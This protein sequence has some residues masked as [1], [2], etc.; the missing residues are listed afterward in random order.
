MSG[1]T[2]TSAGT[3][4]GPFEGCS[5]NGGKMRAFGF[6][7]VAIGVSM[8]DAV[9]CDITAAT[10]PEPTLIKR[11][12]LALYDGAQEGDDAELT[13][14][15]R[16]AEM[17]LN[18]LGF[19]LRFHNMRGRLPD[20]A[21]VERYR[22]VLTWF[23]GSV[24]DGRAY[25]A[26]AS[27][28]SR[29]SV[30]YV[31]LG[32]VGVAVDLAN[33]TAVNR[34]LNLAGLRHTAD[35]VGPTLATRVVQK[36]PHLIGFEC[37]V[38]PVLPDYPVINVA[39]AGTQVGLMLETPKHDGRR[40]TAL[41]AIGSK[42]GYAAL[43][44]E[45][46][47]QR[48]PLYQGK[49]LVNPFSFFSAALDAGDFPIPDTTTVS[50]R[51]LYFARLKGDGWTRSSKIEG[52]RD[53]EAMA[54]E[55]VLRELITPFHDLP[56]TIDVQEDEVARSGRSV[57]Q[58][59]LILQ[60]MLASPNVDPSRRRL[61]TTLSRFDAG[62]PSISNLSPL[63][64]AG[65]DR[66]VNPAMS[67]E[68]AYGAGP[69]GENGFFAVKETET[70]TD[71]P[72]RL[73]PFNLNYHAY[74]GEYPAL[75]QSVKEQLQ[76]AS[77][78]ALTPVSANRYASI[79]DGFLAARIERVGNASWRI[80]DRG[81]LQTVRFDAAGERQV[82]FQSSVGVIGQ[83]HA[84]SALYIALDEAV[85]PAVVVL[86]PQG[87]PAEAENNLALIESRWIIRDVVNDECTSRFE[88]QG[89]GEGAFSWSGAAF[90]RYTIT[91]ARS[92]EELWRQAAQADAAGRLAFVLPVNAIDQV[93]VRMSC[94]RSS[95]F[96]EP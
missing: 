79:V 29:M 70:N 16:F 58:A 90:G 53:T 10:A 9:C 36:D 52:H 78:A 51:R 82:D 87:F 3:L 15:H 18:H 34:L 2:T 21:E 39:S 95:D 43:N 23:V 27:R 89:Y 14:I 35:Y 4:D 62:Y 77:S 32:D 83:K 76:T 84:G 50:G 41:V 91:V 42:G 60:R 69:V 31:I 96:G 1:A 65:L 30:R 38:D 86:R 67:D 25:L 47:H 61:R 28:V 46:C 63:T 44:Y 93:T 24:P 59:R 33:V 75:L 88:A 68:T 12:I 49:W 20:P 40:Q 85:E 92:G 73:K 19:I 45:F 8:I 54:G 5:S 26:W 94:L 81:A 57:G 80:R 37:R 6:C 66:A 17:P 71:S 7:L 64:S 56:T 48:P 74:A 11:E 55:V 13:R 72:R 22:G